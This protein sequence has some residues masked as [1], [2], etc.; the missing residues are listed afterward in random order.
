M[1]HACN[2]TPRPCDTHSNPTCREHEIENTR[3]CKQRG[4]FRLIVVEVESAGVRGGVAI[5]PPP[6]IVAVARIDQH[7]HLTA[8][9]VGV[10][11]RPQVDGFA[12]AIPVLGAVDQHSPVL[13][14]RGELHRRLVADQAGQVVAGL[15]RAVGLIEAHDDDGA[16]HERAERGATDHQDALL[17]RAQGALGSRGGVAGVAAIHRDVGHWSLPSEMRRVTRIN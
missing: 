5:P 7:R 11:R 8:V 17:F 16:Q 12:E 1:N 14:R 13:V 2:S 6:T 10:E 9:G 15:D 3:N 4:C